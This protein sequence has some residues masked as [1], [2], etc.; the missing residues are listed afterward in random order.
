MDGS[1]DQAKIRERSMPTHDTTATEYGSLAATG[2]LPSVWFSWILHVFYF[3]EHDTP[4]LFLADA[5]AL[6]L[7]ISNSYA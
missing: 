4:A 7:C 2:S 3:K 1:V 5:R 6:K